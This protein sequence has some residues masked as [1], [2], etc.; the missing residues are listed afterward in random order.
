MLDMLP[1]RDLEPLRRQAHSLASQGRY[2]E[3]VAIGQRANREC[4]DSLLERQLMNWRHLAFYQH[5]ESIPRPDWPP[6]ASDPRPDLIDRIPEIGPGALNAE[7]LAGALL[8]HGSL[9]VRGLLSQQLAASLLADVDRAYD[10]RANAADDGRQSWYVPFQTERDPQLA[11]SRG[12]S[13]D[14]SMLTSDSPHFFA[15]WADVLEQCGALGAVSAYLAE[16]PVV[17][18][19][20]TRM[21]RV[22]ANPGTQWHQDGAFL[23]ARTRTV[24][25]WVALT[26]CG[27]DAPGLEIVPWRLN[28]IVPPGTHGSIFDWSVGEGKVVELAGD[29]QLV[30]PRYAP[31][32]AMLFDHLCLHR[33]GVRPGMTRGRYALET[34]MFAPSTYPDSSALVL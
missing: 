25:L 12:F 2:R 3:A 20:K 33:T 32:D 26:A 6:R 10:T 34:W 30:S 23:G 5:A 17:S 16:R 13:G 22:P 14:T 19:H 21:Y 31:G 8:N 4:S 9:I 27:E 11:L 28:D 7:N 24:N 15:R 18:A 1:N 29:R